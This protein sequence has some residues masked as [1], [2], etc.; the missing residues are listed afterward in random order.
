MTPRQQ[1]LILCDTITQ[2]SYQA[3]TRRR[4]LLYNLYHPVTRMMQVTR[5]QVP[6]YYNNH[7]RKSFDAKHVYKNRQRCQRCG[8]SVHVEGFQCPAKRYLCK[9]CH[10]FGHFSSLCYQKK[11]I[12][13]KP[14]KPKAHM[15]QLG[16]VYACDKS[17]C[18]HSED[19]SSRD[20]SFCLQ[21]KVQ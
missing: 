8:D 19:L 21:V 6:S 5:S 4:S 12:S 10:K 9:N 16:A 17:I 3:N 14:R 7:N 18:V 20:E 1:K 15:L 11:H 2:I 13:F